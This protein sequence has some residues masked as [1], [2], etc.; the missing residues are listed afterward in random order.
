MIG[1]RKPKHVDDEMQLLYYGGGGGFSD[2][3][4]VFSGRGLLLQIPALSSAAVRPPSL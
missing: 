1:Q 3:L 4:G 2:E